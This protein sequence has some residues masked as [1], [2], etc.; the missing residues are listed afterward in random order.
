[1]L[2]LNDSLHIQYAVAS[3]TFKQD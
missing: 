1:V 2:I 3:K